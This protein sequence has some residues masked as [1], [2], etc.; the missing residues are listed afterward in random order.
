MT[1]LSVGR[2][3]RSPH[4]GPKVGRALVVRWATTVTLGRA[5]IG[6]GEGSCVSDVSQGPDWWLASDGL[7]HPPRVVPPPPPPAAPP[8]PPPSPPPAPRPPRGRQRWF[9]G[10]ERALGGIALVSILLVIVV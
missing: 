3:Y 1:S 6:H 4:H 10:P 5:R 7:W 8:T 9:H 2:R